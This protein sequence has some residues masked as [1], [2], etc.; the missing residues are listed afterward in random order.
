MNECLACV[1]GTASKGAGGSPWAQSE[2]EQGGCPE[3][4]MA[5]FDIRMIRGGRLGRTRNTGRD[6]WGHG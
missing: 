1:R 2:G 6:G 4:M 3:C 5:L